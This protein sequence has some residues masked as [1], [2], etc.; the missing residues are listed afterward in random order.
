MKYEKPEVMVFTQEEID[1][2]I[3]ASACGS[4]GGSCYASC[5]GKDCTFSVSP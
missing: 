5:N 2:I 1:E 4:K 3:D